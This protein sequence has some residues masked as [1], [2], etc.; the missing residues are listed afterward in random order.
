MVALEAF[1]LYAWTA[2]GPLTR[3]GSSRAGGLGVRRFPWAWREHETGQTA[4]WRLLAQRGAAC[5]GGIID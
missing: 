1:V 2:A 5:P 4:L 3:A